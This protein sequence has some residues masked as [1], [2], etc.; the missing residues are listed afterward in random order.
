MRAAG[1]LRGLRVSVR[2]AGATVAAILRLA[3]RASPS[4]VV[5]VVAL[6]VVSA[7]VTPV[8][9]VL[10]RLVVDAWVDGAEA[11]AVPL[12]AAIAVVN[13]LG[14]VTQ[15]LLAMKQEELA[16]RIGVTA[17]QRLLDVAAGVPL[18]RFDESRWY[19]AVAR[20]E[21]DIDWRPELAMAT[22]LRFLGIVT[23]IGGLAAIVGTLQ[24]G[25]LA[26]GVLAAVPMLVHRRVKARTLYRVRRENTMRARRRDY[27]VE[28]LLRPELAKDVRG[29]GLGGAFARGHAEVADEM[30]RRELAVQRR[31][32]AWSVLAGVLSAACLLAAYLV[33]GRH[34][35]GAGVSAGELFLAFT[36]FATL[37]TSVVDLFGIAVDLEEHSAYLAEYFELVDGVPP[38]AASRPSR[39]VPAPPP[40][41]PPET[42]PGMAPSIEFRDVWYT[43]PT[44]V[45]ALRG[46]S[47]TVESGELV[48]LMGENG[49]GKSTVVKLLLGL[50]EPDAGAVLVGGADVRDLGEERV[51]ALVGVLFQ[52]FGRYEF[53]MAEGVRLGRVGEELDRDRM[54]RALDVT[55][56]RPV[57]DRLPQGVDTPVGR[58][59]PGAR[60]LS[61]GQWQRLALARVVYRDAPVW[62][63]DEPTAALDPT[64]EAG[65]LRHLRRDGGPRTVVLVTH[66][67]DSARIADRILVMRDGRL[68]EEGT[69]E[70]LLRSGGV[71]AAQRAAF[72]E[73]AGDVRAMR[74]GPAGPPGR[75][76]P[77]GRPA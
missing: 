6:A 5:V 15:A 7:L 52:E 29:Y 24:A 62:I 19:D 11:V 73:A 18:T 32:V 60:E 63:L 9:L 56:L 61:G 22:A 10:V 44:G 69:H 67:L 49:A 26:L 45:P 57:A 54:W 27:L 43:Y 17:E 8:T 36:A 50:L 16:A 34:A 75:G 31:N 41:T 40:E 68:A 28:V 38:A 23:A 4:L 59:F 64:A 65:F 74:A 20:A 77:G 30:L 42:P 46:L 12:V 33:A 37:T 1:R 2:R 25:M 76:E 39:H 66:R 47:F 71:Y 72:E 55:G 13:A 53:S 51:R 48:A 70:E 35:V 58:Q 3:W 14:T 21:D